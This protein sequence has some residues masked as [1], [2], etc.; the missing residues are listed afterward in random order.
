MLAAV[1]CGISCFRAHLSEGSASGGALEERGMKRIG[2]GLRS[3]S[4]AV[5]TVLWLM[6]VAAV[7]GVYRLGYLRGENAAMESEVAR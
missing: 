4:T 2:Q 3:R 6:A 1:R 7:V 5:V